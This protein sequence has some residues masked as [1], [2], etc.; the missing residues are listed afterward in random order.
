MEDVRMGVGAHKQTLLV[1]LYCSVWWIEQGRL[2]SLEVFAA[3]D[4]RN[5]AEQRN[6]WMTTYF[7]LLVYTHKHGSCPWTLCFV[8]K[9]FFFFSIPISCCKPHQELWLKATSR[10]TSLRASSVLLQV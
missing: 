9:L 8:T 4:L 1:F 10:G 3:E 2:A 5:A 6:P 7:L